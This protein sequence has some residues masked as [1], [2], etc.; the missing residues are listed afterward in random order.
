M[1][2]FS[3]LCLCQRVVRNL[4]PVFRFSELRGVCPRFRVHFILHCTGK[5]VRPARSGVLLDDLLN[6]C[7]RNVFLMSVD[8]VCIRGL[9][10]AMVYPNLRLTEKRAQ[11]YELSVR[12]DLSG[13]E[14]GVTEDGF[15]DRV[16]EVV[17]GSVTR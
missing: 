1:N 14:V 10:Y 13:V 9:E 2:H 3:L 11:L 7:F 12:G 16:G 17:T 4:G 15:G 5:A 8:V 6:K